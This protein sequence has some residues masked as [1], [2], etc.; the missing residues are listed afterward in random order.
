[1]IPGK[2]LG[3]LLEVRWEMVGKDELNPGIVVEDVDSGMEKVR[4]GYVEGNGY[5]DTLKA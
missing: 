1:M 5:E 4:E 2:E 3:K